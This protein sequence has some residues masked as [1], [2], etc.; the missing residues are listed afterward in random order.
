[1]DTADPSFCLKIPIVFLA[2]KGEY[3]KNPGEESH[4]G[5]WVAF[6]RPDRG[7]LPTLPLSQYHRRGEA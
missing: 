1:M 7:R 3:A 6:G 5:S 4:R 2:E